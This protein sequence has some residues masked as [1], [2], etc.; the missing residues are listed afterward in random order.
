LR[1]SP[2]L[3]TQAIAIAVAAKKLNDLRENWL[4][5]P[6]WTRKVPEV[7]PLGMDKSPYP[8]RIEP[9][10]GISEQDLK[11]LQKRTLTNLYN[12]KPAWLTMAHQ[13]LDLAVAAV[14]GWTDYTP[15]MPDDEIL[16]RLLALNLARS[17]VTA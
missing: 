12:A 8:D 6:E 4:N 2:N 1:Q 7:T 15:D 3:K 10:P 14:Y 13:Q 17:G 9:K 5:P 11:A 16:K